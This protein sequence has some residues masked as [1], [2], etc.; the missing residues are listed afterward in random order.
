M[1]G[2]CIR[3]I[4]EWKHNYSEYM[5]KKTWF[6]FFGLTRMPHEPKRRILN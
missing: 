2:D 3:K 4:G 5:K 1:S 6:K